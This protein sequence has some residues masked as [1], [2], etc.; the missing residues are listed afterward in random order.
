MNKLFELS[1]VRRKIVIKKLKEITINEL[2]PVRET[3]N[4][5]DFIFGNE[6]KWE[7][8]K[9]SKGY[10]G[11]TKV[12]LDGAEVLLKFIEENKDNIRLDSVDRSYLNDLTRVHAMVVEGKTEREL[13]DLDKTYLLQI[14]KSK[15]IESLKFAIEM[16]NEIAA[17]MGE[18]T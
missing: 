16:V 8:H 15:I 11:V 12:R 18:I 3:L 2:I 1:I 6:D 13:R 10:V 4:S 9:E 7:Y 17:M 5:I 14:E